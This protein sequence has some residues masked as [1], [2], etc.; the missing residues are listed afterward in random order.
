[1]ITLFYLRYL[2]EAKHMSRWKA[3]AAHL[4]ISLFI[5]GIVASVIYFVWYPPP[6]FTVSG[7]SNLM[8]LIMAVDVV[9][10]P[11]LTLAVFRSGKKGLKLDLTIIAFLQL[12]AFCY[13]L[14]DHRGRA[15]GLRRRGCRPLR[16]GGSKSDKR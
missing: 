8:L 9:L 11:C 13:G 5:A 7:G 14:F 16:S 12:V 15:P 2:S 3:A 6:Y 1:M 10:G 4:G